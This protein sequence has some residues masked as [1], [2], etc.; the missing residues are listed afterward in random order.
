VTRARPT[1]GHL[2]ADGVVVG[3]E[4]GRLTVSVPNGTAFTQDHLKR[5][6]NRELVLET[7]RRLCPGLKDVQLVSGV[8]PA[9]LGVPAHPVVQA[10]IELFDAEV[11][12]VRPGAGARGGSPETGGG[13]AP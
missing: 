9:D 6:E 7:A 2:L 8:S 1:L 12:Q 4:E 10:A 13:E 3:E 5:G 11:T